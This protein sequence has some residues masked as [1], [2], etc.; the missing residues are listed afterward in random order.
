MRWDLLSRCP[1]HEL[2][3]CVHR[4]VAGKSTR[5]ARCLWLGYS[6]LI[7]AI[8]TGTIQFLAVLAFGCTSSRHTKL[9]A[10]ATPA[11]NFEGPV[12]NIVSASRK[13]YISAGPSRVSGEAFDYREIPTGHTAL[14]RIY[15]SRTAMNFSVQTSRVPFPAGEVRNL[16]QPSLTG[17][18]DRLGKIKFFALDF[19]HLRRLL[20]WV[21]A[22]LRV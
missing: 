14:R 18:G 11:S 21:H 3:L 12:R 10:L 6:L 4:S 2:F 20:I 22:L 7:K 19:R 5:P 13:W 8:R 15:P 1:L 17:A 9:F 16:G